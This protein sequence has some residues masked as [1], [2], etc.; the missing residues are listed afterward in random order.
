MPEYRHG[1][2]SIAGSKLIT[3]EVCGHQYRSTQCVMCEKTAENG[4]WVDKVIE[5]EQKKKNNDTSDT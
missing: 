1:P 4:D 5:E 2:Y 3:C